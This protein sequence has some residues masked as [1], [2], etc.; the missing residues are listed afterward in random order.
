MFADQRADLVAA[1]IPTESDDALICPICWEE[2]LFDELTIDHVVP[3]SVGGTLT[4]LTCCRCN[5]DQGSDLDAHLAQFQKT[6]DAFRGRGTLKTELDIGGN[7]LV[8]NLRLGQASNDFLVVGKATDPAASDRSKKEFAGGKVSEVKFKILC[9]Y[10][11]NSFQTA[12]LRAAY[13][14]LFMRCGYEYA[15]H[16]IV[17]VIR[18][19]IIEPALDT[20]RLASLIL[21]VKE[22]APQKDSQHY[23]IRG[24]V[25]GIPLALVIIRVRRETTRYLGVYLPIPSGRSDKFFGMMEACAQAYDGKAVTFEVAQAW[26]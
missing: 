14:I 2:K 19:R 17:Q 5:N 25:S 22:F 15:K 13:L 21:D 8:A 11:E 1:G 26:V 7:R 3:E 12:L 9:G 20:P 4:V 10:T 23:I 16:D 24:K 18:R 6:A